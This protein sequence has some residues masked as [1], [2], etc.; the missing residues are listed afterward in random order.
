MRGDVSGRV[1]G[2]RFPGNELYVC[3]PNVASFG[4]GIDDDG[5]IEAG[6]GQ[7]ECHRHIL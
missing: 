7:V 3:F 6:A 2:D 4:G 5:V 1:K